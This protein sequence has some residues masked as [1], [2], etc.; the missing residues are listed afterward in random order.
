MAHLV[1]FGYI[2]PHCGKA[3]EEDPIQFLESEKC[4]VEVFKC[5]HCGGKFKVVAV[6]I[7]DINTET[8]DVE[9]FECDIDVKYEPGDFGP[10]CPKCFNF[11]PW[12]VLPDEG[13]FK[14]PHCGA[15]LK[16]EWIS[17]EEFKEML[18]SQD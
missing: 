5:P 16:V 6:E 15:E 9:T 4:E 11:I 7:K 13:L 8:G 12:D 10:Y 1:E 18:D 3:V 17:L 2:C 14:C